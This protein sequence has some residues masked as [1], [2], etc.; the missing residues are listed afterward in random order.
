MKKDNPLIELKRKPNQEAIA[1]IEGLLEKAKTGELQGI[2]AAVI[3]NDGQSSRGW[4]GLKE[5]D[6]PKAL[7]ELFIAASNFAIQTEG[8]NADNINYD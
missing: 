6:F 1:H 2:I 4:A 5:K 7:G 8:V 3:W